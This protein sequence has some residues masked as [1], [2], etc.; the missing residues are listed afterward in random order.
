[1]A[2]KSPI[3]II[4]SLLM[5]ALVITIPLA[6]MSAV[7]WTTSNYQGPKAQFYILEGYDDYDG[8]KKIIA[9]AMEKD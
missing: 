3:M 8:K 5:I 9:L 4:L 2:R 7:F 6:S 1:M